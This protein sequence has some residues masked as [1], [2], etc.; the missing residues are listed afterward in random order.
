M[1][2]APIIVNNYSLVQKEFWDLLIKSKATSFGGVPFSFEILQKL[3]FS[4]KNFSKIKTI[5]Q[6]GGKLSEELQKEF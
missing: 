4:K 6:A 1:Q 2:N 5:T 3:N